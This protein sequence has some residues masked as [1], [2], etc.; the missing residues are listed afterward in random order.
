MMGRLKKKYTLCLGAL[1]G[2]SREWRHEREQQ[3]GMHRSCRKTEIGNQKMQGKGR[4]TDS[5]NNLS[6]ALPGC[7]TL[8]WEEALERNTGLLSPRGKLL[9]EA[10]GPHHGW[11]HT[12]V[13]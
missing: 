2:E 1:H 5:G 12:S 10:G 9:L 4:H 3:K 13:L 6:T 8:C 7:G 11:W